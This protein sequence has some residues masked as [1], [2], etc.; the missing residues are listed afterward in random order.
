MPEDVDIIEFL[1]KRMLIESADDS[2]GRLTVAGSIFPPVAAGIG[3]IKDFLGAA[4]YFPLFYRRGNKH[5]VE[6]AVF[7]RPA[8]RPKIWLN[9]LLFVATVITTLIAGAMNSG[10][11]PFVPLKNIVSGVPF[12]FSIMAILT[13]HE[14]G[15]YFVSKKEGMI[16]TLPFFI[17]VPFHLIG[18]LGAIIRMKSIVPDRQALLKVGMAGPLTGFVVSLPIVIAGLLLSEI[19]SS[20]GATAYL[21]L[22][23]SLLFMLIG[24]LIHPS[25]AAGTDIFLHP[26]AFAGWLGWL[27]TSMNLLPI[28]QLDGGHVAYS[29]MLKKRRFIYIPLAGL[30]ILMGW[31]WPG[32]FVWVLLAFFLARRD[33]VIQDSLTPLTKKDKLLAILPLVILILTFI[34]R[35]FVFV[36]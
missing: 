5:V 30:L 12:S 15:H 34:P 25:L 6:V 21:R 7:R 11:N 29:V 19:R 22:G 28:G 1:K 27:V 20:A 3:E 17:P 10:V 33:P 9:V 2:S 23:D 31:L 35:P 18:T 32:W 24:R 16:T 36:R 13:A 26:M 14:L 8:G 4:G